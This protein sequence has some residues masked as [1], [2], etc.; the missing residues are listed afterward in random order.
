MSE[1]VQQVGSGARARSGPIRSTLN[2]AAVGAAIGG[3]LGPCILVSGV[4][5]ES[6]QAN[7]YGTLSN[8]VQTESETVIFAAALTALCGAI[9]GSGVGFL[10][11]SSPK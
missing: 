8:F 9:I 4:I 7:S 11:W 2:G 6:I 1:E 3:I 10:R 5:V